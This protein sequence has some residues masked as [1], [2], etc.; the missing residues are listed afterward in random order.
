MIPTMPLMKT[1]GQRVRERREALGYKLEAFAK[2]VGI[3]NSTLSEFETGESKLPSLEV[4]LKMSQ[5]LGVSVR[6][7]V[8][9]DE[10]EMLIP[11]KEEEELLSVLRD[12]PSETRAAVFTT[13]KALTKNPQSQ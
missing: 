9:G 13:A 3:A 2:K 5:L 4:A 1:P 12:L 7:I 6:W 11:T 10:G 8:F